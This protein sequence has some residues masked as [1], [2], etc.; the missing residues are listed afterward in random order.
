MVETVPLPTRPRDQF[1]TKNA[2]RLRQKGLIPGIIYGHKEEVVAVV[3]TRDDLDRVIRKAAHIVDVEY[4][5][6]TEKARVRELQWDHLGKEVLHVDLMRVSKDERIVIGI[7]IVLRGHAPGTTEGGVLDQPIHVLNVECPVLEI[8]EFIRVNIDKLG[9]GG[10]IHVKEL[11]L[12]PG[13]VAKADP[14][15]VVVHVKAHRVVE[16]PTAPTAE[17]SAEPEVIKKAPKAAEE[18]E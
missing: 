9:L 1:G 17:G 12:P 7:P 2:R 11:T 14:D 13:V 8:P 10:A 6:K 5:G 3:M 15:A 18:E 16:E 4:N